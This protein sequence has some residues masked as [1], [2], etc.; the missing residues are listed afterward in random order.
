MCARTFSNVDVDVPS[1][2]YIYIGSKS[3]GARGAMAPL[4]FQ[5]FP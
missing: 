5:D 4:K 3:R 1:S 2:K